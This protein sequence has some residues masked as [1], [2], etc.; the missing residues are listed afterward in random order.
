[1]HKLRAE[2]DGN[3][4][5]VPARSRFFLNMF[6]IPA[7]SRLFK[8]LVP[9][10][11]GNVTGKV[12]D[13]LVSRSRRSLAKSIVRAVFCFFELI[14]KAENYKNLVNPVGNIFVS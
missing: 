11:C 1:M 3:R 12:P 8:I 2:I 6:P 9:G 5:R 7:R 13:F 10:S 14:E 4:C